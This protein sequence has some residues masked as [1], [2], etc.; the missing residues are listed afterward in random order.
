MKC[1]NKLHCAVVFFKHNWH[2]PIGMIFLNKEA[3]MGLLLY[4]PLCTCTDIAQ[5]YNCCVII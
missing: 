3:Q 2:K 5:N 4:L 1:C